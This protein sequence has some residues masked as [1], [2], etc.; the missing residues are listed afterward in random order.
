MLG[1]K[2]LWPGA[3]SNVMIL[4]GISKRICAISIVTPRLL[5][6]TY[7]QLTLTYLPARWL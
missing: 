1:M 3:S 7:D 4:E 5:H 2:S 6:I